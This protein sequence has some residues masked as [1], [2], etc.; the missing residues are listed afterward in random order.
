MLTWCQ[1]LRRNDMDGGEDS[2]WVPL[3]LQHSLFQII[4][5]EPQVCSGGKASKSSITA[6]LWLWLMDNTECKVPHLHPQTLSLKIWL[7]DEHFACPVGFW[8]VLVWK[9]LAYMWYFHPLA[10]FWFVSP[11]SA[12]H[13]FPSSFSPSFLICF[14]PF[15]PFYFT[16]IFCPFLFPLWLT[17]DWFERLLW[18]NRSWTLWSV[19]WVIIKWLWNPEGF[20]SL[21]IF[22]EI[23]CFFLVI[24]L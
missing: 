22:G 6:S 21:F 2:Y 24:V 10:A 12:P 11:L 16:L 1:S 9:W 5:W 14:F 8:W 3:I 7:H 4:I 20:F 13:C 19:K 18:L 17:T 15:L 23:C